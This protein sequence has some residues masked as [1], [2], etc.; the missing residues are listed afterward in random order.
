M[1]K[2]N[3]PL[4]E[5]GLIALAQS[6]QY[7]LIRTLEVSRL[8]PKLKNKKGTLE[9]FV[10]SPPKLTLQQTK[11]FLEVIAPYIPPQRAEDGIE[12]I[13]KSEAI[14]ELEESFH[15]LKKLP[16][17]K[18]TSEKIKSF[19]PLNSPSLPFEEML[20]FKQL[21]EIGLE[22]LV[23]K[24]GSHSEKFKALSHSIRAFIKTF[25]DS[26]LENS[27][28]KTKCANTSSLHFLS[29]QKPLTSLSS[30]VVSTVLSLTSDKVQNILK[31]LSE[32][33]REDEFATLLLASEE[34]S[35]FSS[36]RSHELTQLCS[37]A[38]QSIASKHK[39]ILITIESLLTSPGVKVQA[40]SCVIGDEAVASTMFSKFLF[41]IVGA[42]HPTIEGQLFVNHY[43]L[44]QDL[45]HMT[46]LHEQSKGTLHTGI[47]KDFF[48]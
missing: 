18:I 14:G 23:R 22:N 44:S 6:P 45:F 25:P 8:H 16:L 15:A 19:L 39:D 20:T 5:A 9:N 17:E 4:L 26:G 40:L 13:K 10:E 3:D 38:L 35:S 48:I 32:V 31:S 7:E 36:T 27:T 30:L 12:N 24:K 46:Y 28:Q 29:P 34:S 42:Q 37:K 43:T 47:L 11:I 1:N 41:L 2:N 33:L 21:Q